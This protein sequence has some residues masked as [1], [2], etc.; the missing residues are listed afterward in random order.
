MVRVLGKYV[1]DDG[2]LRVEDAVRKMTS[3]P[4]Q[5]LRLSD[6]G[7]LRQGCGVDVVVFDPDQVA[8]RA[9][10]QQPKQLWGVKT[11]FVLGDSFVNVV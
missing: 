3:L 5:V 2:V 11:S 8:D 7:V 4:A 9:T 6:R 1:R 10:F